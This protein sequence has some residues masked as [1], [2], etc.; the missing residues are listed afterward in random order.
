MNI[1]IGKIIS[2][3]V[4]AA[5]VIE[6]IVVERNTKKR[7]EQELHRDDYLYAKDNVMNEDYYGRIFN[8]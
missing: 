3:C 7:K 1:L 6:L 2:I 4:A 8:R 5:I